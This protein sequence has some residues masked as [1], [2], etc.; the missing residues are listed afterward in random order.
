MLKRARAVWS[1]VRETFYR[2]IDDGSFQMSASIAF[3][4]AFSMAPALLI[5]VSLVRL[6]YSGDTATGVQA[7]ISEY[8]GDDAAELIARAVT[9]PANAVGGGRAPTMLAIVTMLV[10]ASAVFAQVLSAMNKV[11]RIRP[12]PG[13]GIRGILR[14]RFWPFTMV[15]VISALLFVSLLVSTFVQVYSAYVNRI[16]PGVSFVWHY[17]DLAFSFA[18][19]TVLFALIYKFLPDAR[20]VW[21]DLWVGAVVTAVFFSGGKYLFSIYLST[22]AIESVYGAAGSL[23]VILIWVYF[24]TSI[25]LLGA[26]FTCIYAER[27]GHKV[28]PKPNAVRVE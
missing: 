3:Y 6:I 4:A 17:V 20:V 5:L 15:V 16:V 8:V 18:I 2:W 9:S 28:T 7:Q 24:S 14:D 12:K 22:T 19:V 23:L 13:R 1:L 21:S 11:W 10:G 26:E 25:L 27:H